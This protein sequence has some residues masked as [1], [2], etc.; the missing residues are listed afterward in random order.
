MQ[1]LIVYSSDKDRRIFCV[2]IVSKF[3]ESLLDTRTIKLTA[4]TLFTASTVV[5]LLTVVIVVTAR[6]CLQS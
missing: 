6:Q 2:K 4:P 5:L 1:A 3:A